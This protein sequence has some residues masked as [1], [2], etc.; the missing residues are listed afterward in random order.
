MRCSK[1][2][3]SDT[4]PGIS[5]NDRNECNYCEEN[6]PSYFPKGDDS[7]SKLLKENVRKKSNTDCL[8]GLSGGKD[9][10]YS[11]ITLKEKFNM[12]VEAFTYIHDG[13]T[14]FSIE[15]AKAT[16][17]KLNIKHHIVSLEQHRHLKTFTGFFEA[18]IKSPSATIAGM[19]CVACKHL[20]LLGLK[21]AK[22]R[23]IPMIV[24]SNSPLEYSP[25]LALK[26][27]GNKNKQYK[28][29]SNVKGSLLLITELLKTKEFPRTF[30]KYFNTCL[31]GCLAA[32]P[33]SSYLKKTFPNITPI[34]FYEYHNWNPKD[35]KEYIR[36]RVEWK[37]PGE[38]EDWHSDCLFNYFKEYMFLSMLGA[39]YTDAFLSNQIRYGL[40]SREEALEKLEESRKSN[41][42]G[43]YKAI[44]KLNLHHLKDNI[45]NDVFL[46]NRI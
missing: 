13:S 41:S 11:L 39:S 31:N 26:Y 42:I 17:K 19:T 20:H 46:N 37:I 22:E 9:S 12:R 1:C 7:L 25:F 38:K 45:D 6:F 3:L 36:E 35:I 24:W 15:N 14:S 40:L 2:I 8:V 43:I 18:W 33:T 28:R 29:E 30:F 5:F 10:T 27:T 4:I 21:I 32:F 16:C 44:D 23:N 34:F